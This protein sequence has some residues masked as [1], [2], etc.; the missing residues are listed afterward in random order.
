M[1]KSSGSRCKVIDYNSLMRLVTIECAHFL[2]IMLYCFGRLFIPMPLR[3]S[4][5]GA[6]CKRAMNGG[7]FSTISNYIRGLHFVYVRI[8]V[9][10]NVCTAHFKQL[11]KTLAPSICI[12]STVP[13]FI[14]LLSMV[15]P[16]AP[17]SVRPAQFHSYQHH[18]RKLSVTLSYHPSLSTALLQAVFS[19]YPSN[20]RRRF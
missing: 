11:T 15:P 4:K 10:I 12:V 19:L 20:R 6:N 8:S 9:C 13:S 5:Q 1:G 17:T 2:N 18:V 3:L 16:M 14:S 7:T